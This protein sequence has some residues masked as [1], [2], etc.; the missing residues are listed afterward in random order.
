MPTPAKEILPH[1]SDMDLQ[2]L[3]KAISK[4]AEQKISL[5]KIL[6]TSFQ[7]LSYE[8]AK[9]IISLAQ[10]DSNLKELYY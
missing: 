5:S 10:L 1:P 2:T 3:K 6:C 4:S 7:K 8:K 9:E